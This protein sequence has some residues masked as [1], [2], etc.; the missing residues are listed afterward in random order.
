MLK[1]GAEN[2]KKTGNP[3][4]T[5]DIMKTMFK[6]DIVVLLL[7]DGIMCGMTGVSWLLQLMIFKGY[8]DWDGAG[9]ILQNVWQTIFIGAN[10]GLPRI[11]DWPWSHTVFLVLHTLIMLMKQHSYAFYNGYLS[12]AYKK[13]QELLNKLKQL[14]QI[15]AVRSPSKSHSTTSAISPDY[16]DRP[17]SASE[18][19]QRRRSLHS[20]SDP[21]S[22]DL[23]EIEAAIDL[24]RPLELE[25]IRVFEKVIRWEIDALTEELQGKAASTDLSYPNNLTVKNHY[26]W[27]VFPTLVYELEYPRAETINWRYV[28]EKV[29]ATFGVIFV[30]IMT[31]QAFIYPVVM[32]TVVMKEAGMSLGERFKEFPW[33]LADLIF[34]FMMEYLLSWYVIWEAILNVL[35]EV[36]RFADREFYS[37]WWNSVSWDQFARDWNRPVHNFLLRHVYHSSISA[38]K[39]NKHT[40]T[41]ITFFLSACVHE[42]VMWCIFK[43]LR[44]FLLILQ[45]FQLPVCRISLLRVD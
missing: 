14:E 26:E 31:S 13:R 19:K 44:G 3:L 17:P 18:I 32:K 27:I 1:I 24:N 30:M 4:G 28:F 41:L 2:W 21:F 25:Q 39:V 7:S 5:N 15:E 6:R 36:T 22:K 29:A 12:S 8:M 35:G 10:V 38:M 20:G 23:E 37:D 9:W 40:A 16:L 45:M 34:P 42:L 33:L 43:K 11:R